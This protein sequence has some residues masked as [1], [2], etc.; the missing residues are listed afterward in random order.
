MFGLGGLLGPYALPLQRNLWITPKL[1]KMVV[2]AAEFHSQNFWMY[3][4]WG[5][6]V[7]YAPF[8]KDSPCESKEITA[9]LKAYIYDEIDYGLQLERKRNPDRTI[10]TSLHDKIRQELELEVIDINSYYRSAPY[11]IDKIRQKAQRHIL[12]SRERPALVPGIMTEVCLLIDDEV[13]RL[14]S[15]VPDPASLDSATRVRE[16]EEVCNYVKAID[17]LYD[18]HTS[19]PERFDFEGWFKVSINHLQDFYNEMRVSYDDYYSNMERLCPFP[20]L[21]GENPTRVRLPWCGD[22]SPEPIGRVPGGGTQRGG[23]RRDG[24]QTGG[25]QRGGTQR[26]ATQTDG[27]QADDGGTQRGTKRQRNDDREK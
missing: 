2:C 27:T 6:T 15:E 3:P 24:P 10:D 16:W 8:S 9:K 23:T 17:L 7:C 21:R 11:S 4:N 5:F 19:I 13:I 22:P 14:L 20:D 1:N 18:T 12:C 26:G 25:T